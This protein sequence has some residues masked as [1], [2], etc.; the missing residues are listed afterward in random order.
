M[1]AD[2]Y[3]VVWLSELWRPVPEWHQTK[4]ER[5]DA[6]ARNDTL[7]ATRGEPELPFRGVA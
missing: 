3:A 4:D 6:K 7:D 1:S 2:E 5:A